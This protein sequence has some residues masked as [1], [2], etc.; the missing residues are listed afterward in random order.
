MLALNTRQFVHLRYII[1]VKS[2]SLRRKAMQSRKTIITISGVILF[3]LAGSITMFM[4]PSEPQAPTPAPQQTANLTAQPELPAPSPEPEKVHEPAIWYVYVTGE[5]AKPGI[6]ML[7]EGARVFQAIDAAGGF[8]RKADRAYFNLAD[9]LVDGIQLHVPA[10]SSQKAPQ[11][12]RAPG[13]K[14]Q[15]GTNANLIDINHADLQELQ[16]IKGVGP[17]IAQRI[18]EYRNAHGSFSRVED[19]L[20]VRGIGAGKLNQIRTQIV[21]R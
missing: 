8:T 6:V 12:V 10:K 5:V 21:I 9:I 4:T 2:H 18:I 20:N 1:S 11:V 3:L 19:L 14:A 15:A 13:F 7:S 17:A 16:R